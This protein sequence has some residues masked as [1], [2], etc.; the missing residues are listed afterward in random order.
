[1]EKLGEI[2]IAKRFNGP[3]Q[4][5]NG[6]IGAGR[7]ADFLDGPHTIRIS[8]PIPLDTPLSIVRDGEKVFL[9][10]GKQIIMAARPAE[11][12]LTAPSA[13]PLNVARE[14]NNHLI[15]FGADGETSCFVCGRNRGVGDGMRVWAGEA[16]GHHGALEAWIL[17]Q[18]FCD[19]DDLM[20]PEYMFGA[21][22]CPGG[23]SL[24][25]ENRRVLL[26]EMTTVI[27]QRPRK[28][29]ELIIHAWHDHSDGRKHFAGTALYSADGTLLAQADTLWIQLKPDQIAGMFG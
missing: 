8:A 20:R 19:E 15:N 3:P 5:G 18:A 13:P 6:G 22:D 1:M 7:F 24:P 2:I 29:E 25:E 23:A 21:L 10:N 26:G 27:H 28:G 9:L 17:H 16:E 12:K 4:S 14:A 11:L